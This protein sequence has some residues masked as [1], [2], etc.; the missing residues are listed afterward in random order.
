MPLDSEGNY[1]ISSPSTENKGTT[2]TQRGLG[3]SR[4]GSGKAP[5]SKV[6]PSTTMS[7]LDLYGRPYYDPN[8]GQYFEGVSGKYTERLEDPRKLADLG[9]DMQDELARVQTTGE[10]LGNALLGNV[11][12]AGTTFASFLATGVSALFSPLNGVGREGGSDELASIYNNKVQ[13]G[14]LGFQRNLDKYLPIYSGSEYENA[15]TLERMGTGKF[16]AEFIKNAGFTEGTM[17]ANMLLAMVPYAGPVLATILGPLGEAATEAYNHRT[18][19]VNEEIAALNQQYQ[20]QYNEALKIVDPQQ[21]NQTLQTLST[22]YSENVA[23]I[24]KDADRA[25]N[26]VFGMNTALLALTNF[27]EFGNLIRNAS[28][29]A[30]KVATKEAYEKLAQKALRAG[31]REEFTLGERMQLNRL[32]K[33]E[34]KKIAQKRGLSEIVEEGGKK[35]IQGHAGRERVAALSRWA[36]RGSEE[37]F[38]EGS[39]DVIQKIPYYYGGENGVNDF[40]S[41]VFDDQSRETATSFMGAFTKA[42]SEVAHDKDTYTDMLMGFLTGAIGTPGLR[43]FTNPET[44][45]KQLPFSWNGGLSELVGDF[46]TISERNR[47][48]D[49]ANRTIFNDPKFETLY[50]GLVR[51]LTI[52]TA[53]EGNILD[54]NTKAAKDAQSAQMFNHIRTL[55][56]IGMVDHIKETANAVT[57]MND[58]QLTSFLN[59]L[60]DNNP[61]KNK[62]LNEVREALKASAEDISNSIDYIQQQRVLLDAAYHG[63]MSADT[64][65]NLLYLRYQQRNAQNRK[66][67]LQED[68]YKIYERRAR[69][70][71]DELIP[72]QNFIKLLGGE[73]PTIAEKDALSRVKELITDG[74]DLKTN[75]ED[76]KRMI[77]DYPKVIKSEALFADEFKRM[78]ENIGK[79]NE[80]QDERVADAFNKNT[81]IA[82]NRE[83]AGLKTIQDARGYINA[84]KGDKDI[85]ADIEK[86]NNPQ[87]KKA[88]EL[89]DKADYVLG[90]L[91]KDIDPQTRQDVEKLVNNFL[92]NATLDSQ[93]DTINGAFQNTDVLPDVEGD[94][95]DIRDAR[96][97]KANEII[98]D[99]LGKFIASSV[100][101]PEKEVEVFTPTGMELSTGD[102]QV[103]PVPEANKKEGIVTTDLGQGT[104]TIE[105]DKDGFHVNVDSGNGPIIDSGTK[106]SA[107]KD[108]TA[109][110]TGEIK[111][112]VDQYKRESMTADK[113]G[114][115]TFEPH[116]HPV[117]KKIVDTLSKQTKPDGTIFNAY[118]YINSGELEKY[119]KAGGKVY[120][121]VDPTLIGGNGEPI[122]VHYIKIDNEYYAIGTN[123][124]GGEATNLNNKVIAGYRAN[125]NGQK[126]IHP[127]LSTSV[128]EVM[129][130]RVR[131][132][133]KLTALHN[134]IKN[135]V[136]SLGGKSLD[137]HIV[138][139]D[140]ERTGAPK[141]M[142]GIP[143]ELKK[144]GEAYIAVPNAIG[145]Y[146]PIALVNPVMPEANSLQESANSGNIYAKAVIDAVKNIISIFRSG[147][148]NLIKNA[149]NNLAKYVSINNLD[150]IL[151]NAESPEL[152]IRQLEMQNGK[153]VLDERG[154]RKTNGNR[155]IVFTLEAITDENIEDFVA[156][157]LNTIH[158]WGNHSRVSKDFAGNTHFD[159]INAMSEA[160]A[161]FTHSDNLQVTAAWYILNP[162]QESTEA[163]AQTPTTIEV[164]PATTQ[165]ERKSTLDKLKKL[166]EKKG[167][168][169]RT[170]TKK[171]EP[172]SNVPESVLDNF[173]KKK[174]AEQQVTTS[175]KKVLRNLAK[176]L[177]Q[178]SAED[179]VVIV[180]NLVDSAGSP[181]NGAMLLSKAVMTLNSVAAKGTEYHEAFH[182]VFRVLLNS[183]QRT[184]ILNEAKEHYGKQYNPAELEEFLAD[185]FRDY[186]NTKETFLEKAKRFFQNLKHLLSR[187]KQ[188][189]DNVTSLFEAIAEGKYADNKVKYIDSQIAKSVQNSFVA[190]DDFDGAWDV[191]N[192]LSAHD[193]FKQLRFKK[194][195]TAKAWNAVRD[196]EAVIGIT[197]LFDV[198]Y[199]KGGAPY[200][201]YKGKQLTKEEFREKYI[202]EINKMYT[203]Q[204]STQNNPNPYRELTDYERGRLEAMGMGDVLETIS[205][206]EIDWLLNEG[207]ST[208]FVESATSS[209][210]KYAKSC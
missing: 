107:P 44:G 76:N 95:E 105:E 65:D 117:A 35:S 209:E 162:V 185:A 7:N 48:I 152:V 68:L 100:Q 11:L 32:A 109:V 170:E 63:Q 125:A 12:T 85:E 180:D 124:E 5:K 160:E 148:R 27:L 56:K 97:D 38:E 153:F 101:N 54:G 72:K 172:V 161:L 2:L 42:L 53:I 30:E 41:S 112:A 70:E 177:P 157:I 87:V 126:Y 194:G 50:N 106:E 184:E 18:D 20:E 103:S 118:E 91:P 96:L 174:E 129:S 31:G 191:Y 203:P 73:T 14:L 3:T 8:V 135:T 182:Y 46:Q 158:D 51:D 169:K 207:F 33:Q 19:K 111:P 84:H 49:E 151:T 57:S 113:D 121:G 74:K 133:N 200:V 88:K 90:N 128:K 71:G 202:E 122:V 193:G 39:Q 138:I 141:K 93:F 13:Q 4:K 186:M 204:Q 83:I 142:R 134:A 188:L 154:K 10:A 81:K 175:K 183:T 37:A 9:I 116:D 86:S 205:A 192:N 123:Y 187:E 60:D 58:E 181:L 196:R 165:K 132:L 140:S 150:F 15:S 136:Q 144:S 167:N 159:M 1:Y 61:L 23:T 94:T 67:S 143:K 43:R 176:I 110:E 131:L 119:R 28:R 77:E 127:N 147:D 164:T 102:S 78:T 206:D 108:N 40:A 120:F 114:E 146:N 98:Q 168:I 208:S 80:E 36:L 55:D 52:N 25:G 64:E 195:E 6:A 139:N 99:I 89:Q 45:T 190:L 179:R 29:T 16:W 156:S 163:P 62:P 22:Q 34:G 66:L 145:G 199:G 210:K 104:I 21:R 47:I 82:T 171:E 137:A 69:I 178:L 173:S 155:R 149:V 198:Y 26:I 92:D 189:K 59:D 130:G 75:A 79:A 166:Q 115:N 201:H 24:N 17:A 197:G